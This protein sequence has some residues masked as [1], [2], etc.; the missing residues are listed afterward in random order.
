MA[1]HSEVIMQWCFVLAVDDGC[2]S[3]P[4]H[5]GATCALEK[6]RFICACAP[7]WEGRQCDLSKY[8]HQWEWFQWPLTQGVEL[9]FWQRLLCR[10]GWVCVEPLPTWRNMR[11]WC[12][13]LPVPLW[14]TVGG[15]SV[16]AGCRWVSRSSVPQCLCLQ[17][18]DRGLCVSM[19][20][21]LDRKEL[22]HQWVMIFSL[23]SLNQ[24]ELTDFSSYQF[25]FSPPDINDC[26]NQCQN[27]GTCV[28]S[29]LSI[30][31][32]LWALQNINK[33]LLMDRTKSMDSTAHVPRVSWVNYVKRMW[34]SVKAARVEMADIVWILWIRTLVTVPMDILV[35]TARYSCSP[36][37]VTLRFQFHDEFFS[38]SLSRLILIF[39]TQILVKTVPVVSILGLITIANALMFS[40]AETA[41]WR[42]IHVATQSVKVSYNVILYLPW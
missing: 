32:P 7:G 36:S 19:C 34:M 24:I 23:S 39:V 27:G 29:W 33:Y 20:S 18:C 42:R 31:L 28:V 3:S 9:L 22:W 21:W 38:P 25:C 5:N 4:C 10:C 1:E 14:G 6:G 13:W 37:I 15:A 26:S 17:E 35:W 2:L 8:I 41:P 40:K 16:P 12:G 30:L 11:G